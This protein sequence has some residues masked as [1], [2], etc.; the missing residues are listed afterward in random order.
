M[1]VN[2][3]RN[4]IVPHF[5]TL[6]VNVLFILSQV[7]PSGNPLLGW[8]AGF[9]N[10]RLWNS[11]SANCNVQHHCDCGPSHPQLGHLAH[12]LHFCYTEESPQVF[13]WAT[14][15]SHH[16][17]GDLI[18]VNLTFSLQHRILAIWLLR[19]FYFFIFLKLMDTIVATCFFN[20][21]TALLLFV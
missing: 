13:W 12:H 7:Y 21:L 2:A 15:C 5:L 11:R 3:N 8:R 10:R 14:Q 6:A 17:H 19:P 20:I 4:N 16:S 9:A 18:Q 1:T